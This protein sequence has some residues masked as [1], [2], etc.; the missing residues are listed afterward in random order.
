[1]LQQDPKMR[2]SA[3]Q[4]LNHKWFDLIKERP[5]C[6]ARTF[7]IAGNLSEWRKAT[8][9]YRA[10]CMYITTMISPDEN[11]KEFYLKVDSNKDGRL[12]Y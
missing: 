3:S 8:K 12:S 1:M 2:P 9:F 6:L 5:N 10:M 11:L 7:E 4:L